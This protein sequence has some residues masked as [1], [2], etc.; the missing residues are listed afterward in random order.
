[1]FKVKILM[2]KRQVTKFGGFGE[3]GLNARAAA[4]GQSDGLGDGTGIVEK[5]FGQIRGL[6][7]Y[8]GFD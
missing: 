4:F 2:G 8:A 6:G 3:I 5:R 1:M 7:G